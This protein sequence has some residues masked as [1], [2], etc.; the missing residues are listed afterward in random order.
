MLIAETNEQGAVVCVSQA[1]HGK[2]PRP[3]LDAASCLEALDSFGI[4]GASKDV[5]SLGL[6]YADVKVTRSRLRVAP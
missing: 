1:D 3:V 2:R 4:S 5:V 6:I